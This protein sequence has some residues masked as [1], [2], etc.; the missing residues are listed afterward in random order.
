MPSTVFSFSASPDVLV[1]VLILTM[2]KM[3]G[4]VTFNARIKKGSIVRKPQRIYMN[5]CT[6]KDRDWF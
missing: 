4:I 6:D 5:T 3:P 1:Y 2:S